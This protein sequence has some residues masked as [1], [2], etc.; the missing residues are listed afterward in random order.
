MSGAIV[1]A[2]ASVVGIAGG[3][4]SI[5]NSGGSAAG[6]TAGGAYYDP[7]KEQRPQWF[8]GL[9]TLM[10]LGGTPGTTAQATPLTYAEWV[11]QNPTSGGS[12]PNR[13]SA[14]RTTNG[15]YDLGSYKPSDR[16][17]TANSTA[18][19]NDYVKNFKPTAGTE[20]ISGNQAAINMVMN[21]PTYMGGLQSGQRTLNAGLAR[22][23]QV[24]SGA[25]QLALQGYGQ[26][27]FNSQYQNLYNQ[28]SG[29]SQATNAPLNMANQNSLNASQDQNAWKAIAGG[30]QGLSG[31]FNSSSS[32][33][34]YSPGYSGYSPVN[35]SGSNGNN[36]FGYTGTDPNMGGGTMGP[37][38][39]GN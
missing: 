20:G 11:K 38:W 31:L 21:S 13:Y 39:G 34:G 1:G 30:V 18:S 12:D 29:L 9:Q 7:Y 22:S 36:P 28:Y 37:N 4:N 6:N 32:G 15:L 24:G 27:Y 35:T 10:G 33:S 8:A 2:A 5:M 19:Y 26:D 3:I 16:T 25:E 14:T 17:N 23:G